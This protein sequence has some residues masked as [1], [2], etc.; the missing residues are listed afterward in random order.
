MPEP[1]CPDRRPP[2]PCRAVLRA[3]GGLA[4]GLAGAA[5]VAPAWAARR[6]T[7]L[8]DGPG[9]SAAAQGV[10]SSDLGIPYHREHDGTWG[11]VFGD[12]WSGT[13]QYGDYLGSPLMPCRPGFDA[14]GATPVSFT[15]A[16]PTG[17]Q[18]RRL[19]AY[20]TDADNGFGHEVSR[21]PDDCVEFGGRT[22]IQYTS[23]GTREPP[24]G[25]DGSLMSGVAYTDDHGATW[26]YRPYHWAGKRIRD[27]YRMSY[28][29]I[30]DHSIRT[31]TAA[32]P[33]AVCGA[34]PSSRSSVTTCC[35][36]ATGASHRSPTCTAATST[37]AA[38]ARPR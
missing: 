26:R 8:C 34:R 29:D 38:R 36:R 17:G 7:P 14:S 31:R 24:A 2:V 12:T 27:R 35:R 32:P 11:Y 20:R 28:F 37:R 23:V 30:T 25:H 3:G 4:L 33:D 5:P 13:R 15:W 19:F 16:M 9:D 21:I 1:S 22:Y 6:G 18:A 10:T